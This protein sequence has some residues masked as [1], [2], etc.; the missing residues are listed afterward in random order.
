MSQENVEIVR[1]AVAAFDSGDVDRVFAVVRPDFEAHVVPEIS[2]EPDSYRG[3]EGIR[4][5]FDSFTEAFDEIRF[6]AEGLADAGDAVVVALRMTAIGK[7]TGIPVEQR[8]AGVWTVA[9]G[10]IAGIQTYAALADAMKAAG[11]EG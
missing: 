5:Y 1:Q 6:E 4:R 8:N 2:A 10:K 3:Q 7:R 9:G 11:L